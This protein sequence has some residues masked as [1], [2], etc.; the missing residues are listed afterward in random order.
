MLGLNKLIPAKVTLIVGAVAIA[1][2]A[3]LGWIIHSKYNQI[4]DLKTSLTLA[5]NNLATVNSELALAKA[6]SGIDNTSTGDLVLGIGL[7][8]K[9]QLEI[10]ER[11]YS[12][13]GEPKQ[14]FSGQ[15]TQAMDKSST[16]AL[17]ALWDTFCTDNPSSSLCPQSLTPLSVKG[18]VP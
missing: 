13:S 8:Y 4:A 7:R 6:R 16:A 15:D 11:Q 3:T 10:M 14:D 1:V 5:Q 12:N 17:E 18:A 2:I 9:K